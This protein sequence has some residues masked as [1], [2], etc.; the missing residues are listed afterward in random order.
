MSESFKEH[1][2][3]RASDPSLSRSEF[4]KK[5]VQAAAVTGGVLGAPKIL[6]KFLV[7][8]AYAATSTNCT[9][10]DTTIPSTG[11]DVVVLTGGAVFDVSCTSGDGGGTFPC[12]ANV[13]TGGVC[14]VKKD[15]MLCLISLDGLS[16][17][18][19]NVLLSMLPKSGGMLI[20]FLVNELK[21]SSS[22]SQV[23]WGEF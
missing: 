23:N 9:S 8:P 1:E 20:S 12:S 4:V 15:G 5:V 11:T 13:D 2:E 21:T 14:P 10:G 16:S 22:D 3:E 19:M 7:P 18:D 17:D 6:D